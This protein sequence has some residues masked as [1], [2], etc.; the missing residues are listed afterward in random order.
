MTN[1]A[2]RDFDGSIFENAEIRA[3]K[4]V[5]N[6]FEGFGSGQITEF[7]HEEKAWRETPENQDIYYSFA[8]TLRI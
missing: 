4:Y 1:T 8:S 6:F 7:S 2:Q 5:N 3:L